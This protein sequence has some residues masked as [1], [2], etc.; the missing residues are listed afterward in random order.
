MPPLQAVRQL[1]AVGDQL[2]TTTATAFLFLGGILRTSFETQPQRLEADIA[3]DGVMELLSLPFLYKAWIQCSALGQRGTTPPP[4]TSSIARATTVTQAANASNSFFTLRVI[5]F[6]VLAVNRLLSI[7]DTVMVLSLNNAAS[8]TLIFFS[9]ARSLLRY[10]TYYCAL[11]FICFVRLR[12]LWLIVAGP[13]TTFRRAVLAFIGLCVV[14]S[15]GIISLFFAQ[16]VHLTLKSEEVVTDY[17]NLS[18]QA[19]LLMIFGD[20]SYVPSKM[21]NFIN[22][23]G[24]PLVHVAL[25]AGDVTFHSITTGVWTAKYARIRKRSTKNWLAYT[26]PYLVSMSMHAAFVLLTIL[27]RTAMAPTTSTLTPLG[28]VLELGVTATCVDWWVYYVHTRPMVLGVVEVKEMV[29]VVPPLASVPS[30]SKL[31]SAVGTSPA[32]SPGSTVALLQSPTQR[33]MRTDA[34]GVDQ[35][36]VKVKKVYRR[37]SRQLTIVPN[38]PVSPDPVIGTPRSASIHISDASSTGPSYASL[39]PPPTMPPSSALPSP[40]PPPTEYQELSHYPSHPYN[41]QQVPQTPREQRRRDQYDQ[42]QPPRRQHRHHHDHQQPR[43]YPVDDFLSQFQALDAGS[44][45]SHPSTP[46]SSYRHQQR[47]PYSPTSSSLSPPRGIALIRSAGAPD[48]FSDVSSARS[49]HHSQSP[50]SS[51]A[52]SPRSL[53]NTRIRSPPSSV[54]SSSRGRSQHHYDNRRPHHHAP[55]AESRSQYS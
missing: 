24:L 28:F 17:P 12:R 4:T 50:R 3:L 10:C 34:S 32:A 45:V 13:H 9:L 7:V 30:V 51:P 23:I 47:Q 46:S 20:V 43:T 54:T 14:T 35:S 53:P 42:Q 21:W 22:A 48:P 49:H 11:G 44:A 27:S 52:A 38:G 31:N 29:I 37:L 5:F 25:L 8:E 41:E 1:D 2:R 39:L 55:D 16:G 36:R 15:L 6:L 18:R 40:I 26:Y 33:G 19:Q